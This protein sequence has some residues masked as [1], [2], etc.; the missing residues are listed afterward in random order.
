MLPNVRL[1]L[2]YF[3]RGS[4]MKQRIMQLKDIEHNHGI[5]CVKPYREPFSMAKVDNCTYFYSVR[6][7]LELITTVTHFLDTPIVK[8]YKGDLTDSIEVKWE[9]FQNL[10]TIK[11][12]IKEHDLK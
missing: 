5:N 7:R 10:P 6:N 4:I 11:K 8:Y 9:W 12:F 2:I 1:Q 3:N